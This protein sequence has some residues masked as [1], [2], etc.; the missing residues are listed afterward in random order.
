MNS[1]A[2]CII[3]SASLLK[4]IHGKIEFDYFVSP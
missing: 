4:M 3:A 2:T 1:D